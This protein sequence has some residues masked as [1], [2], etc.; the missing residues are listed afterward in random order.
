MTDEQF[1][2]FYEES[3]V[4][5]KGLYD[6]NDSAAIN[7]LLSQ[8]KKAGRK[9]CIWG[10]G[11]KTVYFL[12]QFDPQSTYIHRLIDID[13]EKINHVLPTGHRIG[14]PNDL[15]PEDIVLIVTNIRRYVEEYILYHYR[16][17]SRLKLLTLQ[18]YLNGK[19]TIEDIIS[20]KAMERIKYNDIN[21]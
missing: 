20:G 14:D 5:F 7:K 19:Y 18:D 10:V 21:E 2:R 12:N 16:H 15:D 3:L 1:N 9:I 6:S 4:E 8:V 11:K 13:E 17:P